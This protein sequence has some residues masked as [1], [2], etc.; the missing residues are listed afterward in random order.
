VQRDDCA[1]RV[2]HLC[3]VLV[4]RVDQ[5]H[6]HDETRRVRRKQAQDEQACV[7]V[8]AGGGL[9]IATA[10]VVLYD[11]ILFYQERWTD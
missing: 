1:A 4:L 7:L 8:E 6:A 10:G 11:I 9:Q 2:I 5:R 3:D